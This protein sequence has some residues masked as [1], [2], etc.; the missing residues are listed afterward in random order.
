MKGRGF[1]LCF[2]VYVFTGLSTILTTSGGE[3]FGFYVFT[4]LSAI[5]TTSG[6]SIFLQIKKD[7]APGGTGSTEK[8]QVSKHVKRKEFLPR[9]HQK[10]VNK[11]GK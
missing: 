1:L 6:G 7:M 10:S 11:P 2:R 5:P 9:R 8:N 3:T 4:S